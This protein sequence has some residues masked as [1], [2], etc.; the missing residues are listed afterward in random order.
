M[1][2]KKR[3]TTT[4]TVRPVFSVDDNSFILR[5]IEDDIIL[6]ELSLENTIENIMYIYDEY[7]NFRYKLIKDMPLEF[8]M[9]EHIVILYDASLEEVRDLGI[10]IREFTKQME[11]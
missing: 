11:I 9:G 8:V 3:F 7:I 1:N 5:Y 6:Y 2:L 4:E 10:A